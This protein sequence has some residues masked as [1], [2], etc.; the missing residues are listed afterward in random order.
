M[1]VSESNPA[2]ELSETEILTCD[3]FQTLQKC[4]RSGVAYRRPELISV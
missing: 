1:P 2:I 3:V 4:F